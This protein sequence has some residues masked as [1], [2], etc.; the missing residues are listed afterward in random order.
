MT[1]RSW[2]VKWFGNAFKKAV[3]AKLP[4][5]PEIITTEPDKPAIVKPDHLPDATNM[6]PVMG[7]PDH[8]GDTTGMIGTIAVSY[9]DV[10]AQTIDHPHKAECGLEEAEGKP[11]RPIVNYDRHILTV[12]DI[13]YGKIKT[14]AGGYEIPAVVE[15]LGYQ[16]TPAGYSINDDHRDKMHVR[17]EHGKASYFVPRQFRV[18]L[19]VDGR[20]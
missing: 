9:D 16:W 17:F 7:R 15:W 10:R 4:S 3:K 2:L 18:F 11:I 6:V 5:V 8:N 19:F 12:S 14:V 1:I 20:K 13:Y